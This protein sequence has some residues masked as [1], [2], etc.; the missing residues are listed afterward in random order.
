MFDV[1]SLLSDYMLKVL[2]G[3]NSSYKLS[4][5]ATYRRQIATL[6]RLDRLLKA[7][8]VQ[9][10]H[11]HAVLLGLS[12]P[13][14]SA[15]VQSLRFLDEKLNE[16]QRK[17]IEHSLDSELAVIHGPPGL[18]LLRRMAI[19]FLTLRGVTGTGKTSTIIELIRQ[20]LERKPQCQMLVAGSS[21]LAVDNILLRLVQHKVAVTRLGHPARVL[22]GMVEHTLDA[23]SFKTNA[24]DVLKDLKNEI[25]GNFDKLRLSGKH[26]IRGKERNE[27]WQATR[28][29][30]QDLSKR[31]LKVTQEV[32][33]S[34]RVVLA[35]CHGSADSLVELSRVLIEVQ[36]ADRSFYKGESLT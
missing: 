13:L 34:A 33:G 10:N 31:E 2:R 8:K 27:L 12:T 21:N 1:S 24:W 19:V 36:D 11:L 5:D 22:P 14:T 7:G 23:Q 35:T 6:E 9:E 29:L 26:R 17:A 16:S 20:T 18:S 30:R 28:A 15:P 4:D 25:D 32:L 3:P